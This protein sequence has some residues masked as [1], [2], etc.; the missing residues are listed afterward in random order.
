MYG[1][2]NNSY[3]FNKKRAAN[4]RINLRELNGFAIILG[5]GYAIIFA[6]QYIPVVI[7]KTIFKI[8]TNIVVF[9]DGAFTVVSNFTLK[10]FITLCVIIM[11]IVCII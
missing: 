11:I 7:L 9:I 4:P 2:K 5:I 8:L 1:I 10:G 3:K 6:I